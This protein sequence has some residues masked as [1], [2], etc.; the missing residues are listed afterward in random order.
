[1]AVSLVENSAARAKHDDGG[2]EAA[3]D[4]DGP[5]EAEADD[6]DLEDGERE[7]AAEGVAAAAE[8]EARVAGADG[9]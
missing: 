2:G 6:H 8:L 4:K 7:E 9:V 1:M 3:G 5:D